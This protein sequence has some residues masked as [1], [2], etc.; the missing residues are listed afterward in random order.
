MD[1][2]YLVSII[3]PTKNRAEYAL[4]TAEQILSITDDNLQLIIQDNSDDKKLE[5]MISHLTE[6]KRLKYN[7]SHQTLSF[8]DNFGLAVSHADGEYI[9]IIG[10][11]DGVSS[12]II[13]LTRWASK[14]KIKAIKPEVQAVY[15]WPD[16]IKM[17][18]IENENKG[19]M[20]VSK[21]TEEVT[22]V[23]TSLEIKKLLNN[24]CQ[25][26][27]TLNLVKLYH[28]LV[29]KDCLDEV[30]K[31]TGKFFGGLSPDI[32][33][34][35]ALSMIIPE[36]V[37]IDYPITISGICKKSGS[38]DSATGRH[39]GDLKDAPH[40]VGQSD[41]KWSDMVPPFYSVETIWA[42]SALAAINDLSKFSLLEDFRLQALTVH[43][44]NKYKNYNDLIIEHFIGKDGVR[45]IRKWIKL[46]ELRLAMV[47][48][49][50]LDFISRGFRRLRKGRRE[51]VKYK[52]INNIIEA[53]K[54]L[55]DHLSA[56]GLSISKVI[57]NIAYNLNFSELK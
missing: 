23:D 4:K 13:E 14:H 57:N 49:P 22:I 50:I 7:Y 44:L 43:C 8:V 53:Q 30:F 10:D 12:E 21:I 27:L 56:K 18:E 11:D 36:V 15:F 51:I 9:C 46:S 37:C 3:V 52:D 20:T 35:V 33:S 55:E 47:Y 31:I 1:H 38:A 19:Y 29:R 5:N 28:G 24:G 2:E 25:R 48:V 39:T 40:F 54:V 41:Y 16:A 32:Y 6:D 45:N 26:Y 17:S 42:D 34:A